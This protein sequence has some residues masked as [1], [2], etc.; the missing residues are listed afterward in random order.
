MDMHPIL[1]ILHSAYTLYMIKKYNKT[2]YFSNDSR[3]IEGI[4]IPN[5]NV[6]SFLCI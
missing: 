3:L 4:G 6:Y 1:L 5:G 2:I